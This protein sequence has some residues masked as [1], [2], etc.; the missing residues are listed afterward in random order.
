MLDLNVLVSVL[1]AVMEALVASEH[2]VAESD[3]VVP[4]LLENWLSII[5]NFKIKIFW[6]KMV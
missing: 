2:K 3:L 1:I 5:Q 6:F 4:G